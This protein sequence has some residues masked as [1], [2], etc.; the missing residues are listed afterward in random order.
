MAGSRA[1]LPGYNWCALLPLRR[2]SLVVLAV[3]VAAFV[4]LY[5]YLA[6]M[7]MCEVGE[8]PYAAQSSYE[9]SGG[10]AA[11]CVSAVL[12]TSFAMLAFAASR[13]RRFFVAVSRPAEPYLSPD[14]PPP[15]LSPI[16]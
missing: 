14:P 5:P 10:L 4:A 16:V 1:G 9:G 2:T 8:C 13:G 7:D 6:G 12:A 3:L 11:A 15:R